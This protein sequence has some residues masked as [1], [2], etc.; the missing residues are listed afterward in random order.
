VRQCRSRKDTTN[1]QTPYESRRH[2]CSGVSGVSG[3]TH[4]PGNALAELLKEVLSKKRA[5]QC[6]RDI[7]QRLPE[8]YRGGILAN[9]NRNYPNSSVQVQRPHHTEGVADA[10]QR[11]ALYARVSTHDQDAEMQLHELRQYTQRRAV[12]QLRSEGLS[13]SEVCRATGLSKGTAQRAAMSA[14][15]AVMQ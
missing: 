10:I 6:F 14:S 15:Q 9:P 4:F 7:T 12:A 11:V 8:A 13:W 3:C 5:A 2:R 1:E